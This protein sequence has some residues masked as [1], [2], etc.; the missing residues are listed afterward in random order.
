MPQYEMPVQ[1]PPQTTWPPQQ[2][3]FKRQYG[4]GG[5]G[6]DRRGGGQEFT[7][8]DVSQIF[9]LLQ[10]ASENYFFEKSEQPIPEGTLRELHVILFKGLAAGTNEKEKLIDFLQHLADHAQEERS[11]RGTGIKV[12]AADEAL[13]G[14]IERIRDKLFPSYPDE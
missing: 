13:R 2:D 12:E 1:S 3:P 11:R 5:G 6:G 4:G 10:Q 8:K 9:Q 7:P 14:T